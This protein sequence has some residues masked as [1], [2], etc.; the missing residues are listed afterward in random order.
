MRIVFAAF[1]DLPQKRIEQYFFIP[2]ADLFCGEMIA[3]GK[4]FVFKVEHFSVFYGKRAPQHGA[5]FVFVNGKRN[6]AFLIVPYGKRSPPIYDFKIYV[7]LFA[8]IIA[9]IPLFLV[10]NVHSGEIR[11]RKIALVSIQLFRL[12]RNFGIFF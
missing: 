1:D 4:I 2:P 7:S 12:F 6:A 5:V 3:H 8:D 10:R 9:V 11:F